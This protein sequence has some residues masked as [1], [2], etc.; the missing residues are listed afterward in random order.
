MKTFPSPTTAGDWRVIDGELVDV[1]KTPAKPQP[2]TPPAAKPEP[3]T[4]PKT[5]AERPAKT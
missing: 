2:S 1:S 5:R 4:E 3:P